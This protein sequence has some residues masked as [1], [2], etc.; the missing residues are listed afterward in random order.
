[1]NTVEILKMEGREEGIREAKVLFVENLLKHTD[2]SLERIASFVDVTVDFVVEV[3]TRLD[4]ETNKE[5]IMDTVD[6]IKMEAKEEVVE[7]LLQ[8]SMLN[9]TV[10]KIAQL[11]KVPVRAVK[12][13]KDELGI[14]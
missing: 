12:E 3:Q 9:L 8:D 5:I 13:I 4:S 10:E 6:I 11:T 2:E 1:M 14:K 7:Q